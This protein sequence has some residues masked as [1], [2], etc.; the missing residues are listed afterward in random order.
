MARRSLVAVKPSISGICRSMNTMS[1]AGVVLL[2]S[3]VSRLRLRDWRVLF[4]RIAH[5]SSL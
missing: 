5:D 1:T 2:P 3:E 4:R